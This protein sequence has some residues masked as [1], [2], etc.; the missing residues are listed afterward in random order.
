M[1]SSKITD[2]RSFEQTFF[3]LDPGYFG[4]LPRPQFQPQQTHL[5]NILAYNNTTEKNVDVLG[6][7]LQGNK[8]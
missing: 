8:S 6:F 1:C 2:F 5:S 7:S 4:D 3:R